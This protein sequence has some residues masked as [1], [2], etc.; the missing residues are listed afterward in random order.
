MRKRA[1]L[2][3][4]IIIIFL[5]MAVQHIYAFLNGFH[6][7][8][9]II[10]LVRIYEQEQ[11]RVYIPSYIF[12]ILRS[13]FSFVAFSLIFYFLLK[14]PNIFLN[15]I[16]YTYDE[17]KAKRDA[18]K[19]EREAAAKEARRAELERELAELKKTE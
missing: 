11:F 18:E 3:T 1:I 7:I 4:L 14:P 13:F 19:A 2:L 9:A 12:S 6:D 8:Q 10:R 16:R 5:I 17:Y 15:E